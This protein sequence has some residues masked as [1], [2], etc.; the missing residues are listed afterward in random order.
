M[1]DINADFSTKYGDFKTYY[2]K[3]PEIKTAMDFCTLLTACTILPVTM[4]YDCNF[5]SG[6]IERKHYQDL[7]LT[8]ASKICE[9]YDK[10]RYTYKITEETI[11]RKHAGVFA[12]RLGPDQ[13][14]EFIK[15]S[16]KNFFTIN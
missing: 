2:N 8:K 12:K 9:I 11:K 4:I 7:L 1:K 16:M 13:K 10:I 14:N 3:K 15:A 6:R 5:Q